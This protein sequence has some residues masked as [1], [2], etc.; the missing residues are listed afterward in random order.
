MINLLRT[1]F[2]LLRVWVSCRRNLV[3]D[4]DFRDYGTNS[5]TA[6]NFPIILK[7]YYNLKFSSIA[8]NASQRVLIENRE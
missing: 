4:S 8:L 2:L 6:I 7:S 1:P 3:K 5:W